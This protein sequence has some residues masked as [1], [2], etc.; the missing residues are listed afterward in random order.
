M[1]LQAYAPGDAGSVIQPYHDGTTFT[2]DF[3]ME[4]RLGAMKGALVSV[5]NE[6]NVR[7]GIMGAAA[8]RGAENY[9]VKP[10]PF[11]RWNEALTS[12]GT[13]GWNPLGA[14]YRYDYTQDASFNRA[15]WLQAGCPKENVY[16][17]WADG[18]LP[19]AYVQWSWENP[20]TRGDSPMSGR[21][22][23]RGRHR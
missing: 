22:G 20:T 8:A 4:D 10:G 6:A 14:A 18:G 15:M 13:N 3:W 2:Q 9:V 12:P 1:E 5:Y 17:Q 23:Y 11:E 21:G 7:L 19:L 16:G